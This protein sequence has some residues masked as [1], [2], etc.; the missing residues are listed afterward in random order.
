MELST[1][2]RA[3]ACGC[4]CEFGSG[5]MYVKKVVISIIMFNI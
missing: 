3:C 5:K 4:V 1:G 2:E